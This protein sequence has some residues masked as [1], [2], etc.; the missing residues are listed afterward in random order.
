MNWLPHDVLSFL[1][2]AA[3]AVVVMIVAGFRRRSGKEPLPSPVPATADVPPL[4]RETA[5]EASA[6]SQRPP[7]AV[8]V[9]MQFK[10][11]LYKSDDCVWVRLESLARFEADGYSY[12]PHPSN[13]AKC[14]RG[15]DSDATFLMV[16]PYAERP[17]E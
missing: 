5:P 9:D 17:A 12:Y 15:Y 7:D 6:F 13:G 8:Q 2:G 1:W 14:V 3:T 16:N 11:T 10:P 4:P